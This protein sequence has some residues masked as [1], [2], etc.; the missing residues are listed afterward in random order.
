MKRLITT[1]I[2]LFAGV[3]LLTNAQTKNDFVKGADMGFLTQQERQGVKFYD[4]QGRQRDCMELLKNDYQL[5]AIRMR[6]WVNPRNGMNDKNELLAMAL[7]AKKLGMDLMVDFHYADSWAD[8]SQQPIPA[9]WQGH[10]FEQM[11]NDLRQHTI[12]VLNLLKQNGITPRWVQVGNE[13]ANGLLW[14]MGHSKDN[15]QQYAGFIRAGYDAVKE[16]FPNTIVIVH[17]DRGH[18]QQLYDWNLDIVKKY[19]GRFDMVGMSLYP[20]WARRDHP[21]LQADSIITDCIRN[22]RHVSQKYGCDVMIVETGYEVD[23]SHPEVMDDGRRQLARVIHEARTQTGGHCRGV[24]YWEPQCLP[25][26]HHYNLGAFDSKGRPTAIMDGFIEAPVV[27]TTDGLI[28]GTMQE[29]TMAYLGIPYARVERFMPPQP[30][31]K[32]QGIRACDHWGPQS[33]QP[34][35]RPMSEAEMSEQCCALNVWTTTNMNGTDKPL[36]PVMLWLH[37]GGFDSGTSAW[38]PGQQLAKKDVVVVSVNHRLN[39]LGFLDLSAVSDKY[40][41]SGNVGMLDVVQALKWIRDNIAKFGGDPQNVTVFGESGGGGKVGTLMCM[42]AAQGL[43]HKAI[44]MSGTILNVNTHQ[45]TQQ[46]GKA[47][48]KELGISENQVDRIK[49]V[50]YQQLYQAGQRAMAASIGTRKPGTPMMWGFGPTPDGETLL[51]QPFQPGFASISDNIPLMIG[52][53]FNELQRLHYNRQMTLEEARTELQKT[54]GNETDDYIAAFSKTYPDY[55]PQDLLSIDWL[56]R[57]KTI[58]T[59]DHITSPTS[60]RPQGSTYMYMFNWRSPV[61]KGS[62]HG[63]E[64][65]FCFN[66][67]HQAPNIVPEPTAEDRQLANLMSSVWAQFAHNGNPNIEGLPAWNA[68]TPENGELMVFDH[69]C[70]TRNNPDREL[71]RIIDRHCFRQLDKFRKTQKQQPERQQRREYT[72]SPVEGTAWNAPGNMNPIIPGYFADPTIR[73]F[74]DTYYIYATTD[75]TGNGYGPAQVW[76]SK[77]FVNWKNIVMNWPTTEVVWA[78][79]VVQQPD[80]KYRYY[81]CEPCNIN[82]GES[83]SPIGPW[84][85]ILGKEDA[86]MVPDRYI[87]NVITLDPQLFRDDDGC[88]YLYFTTWGIYKGFGCGVAKLNP[89]SSV[90]SSQFKDAR[91]WNEN[92]PFPIAADE[93]FSEKR[94]IPNTELKDIFEAPFVFKRNGIYYFTYSSG[95]CH[96]D[97][98]RVQYAVSKVG[99]MGPFTYKGELLTTNEDETVHGP[100]HHSILEQDGRYYIVY[101]RHNNP[102]SVHGFNRQVCIDE[103]KF[104]EEGNILRVVP[105]HNARNVSI[106]KDTKH[107]NLAYGAKVTA[108]SY[109]DEWFKPEYAVDDNNATLWKAARCNWD[110]QKPCTSHEEWLQIDLGKPMK[111]NEVWTQFEY[112][113]FFYQYRI[114]TSTD[115]KNWTMFANRTNNTMQGSPM[116]DKGVV[117]AQYLRIT[118]TDTQKNGHMPAIWNVKVW[119]KAPELPDT[120]VESNDGYPGMHK[121]D[122]EASE[123]DVP[124]SVITLN[125]EMLGLKSAAKPFDVTEVECGGESFPSMTFKANKPIRA[126]VKDGRWG[127]FFNGTQQLV[128]EKPLPQCYRYNAPYTIAAWVLSTKVGPVSTVASLSTSRADLATTEFRLGT[129]PQTGLLNHNGS[130]ESCGAPDE[131]KAGEGKWQFWTVTYDGWKEKVYLNGKLVKE[132]NN[133]L[134][135]RPDGHITIGADG[136]GANNFMGYINFLGIYPQSMPAEVV[137]FLYKSLSTEKHPSLGD[138]DFEEIDPDSKFTLSDD[139][140]P[141]FTKKEPFTL[142]AKT[143]AFNDDPLQN[144][145][146][147]YQEVEGDFV[148]MCRVSDME[149]LSQSAVKGYNE[150]GLLLSN[151]QGTYYQLGA[152]PLYNCG[153]MLTILGH[154]GRPQFPNYK[155]YDFDPILQFE[156]RGNQLFARTSKDGKEWTNMPGSPITLK[157]PKVAIG[158]YQTTYSDNDSW[159]K[160]SDYVIYVKK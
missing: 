151:G 127:L 137:E 124:S 109:Y 77:D 65:C 155:G 159:A 4:L 26:L 87:H 2:S 125:V 158:S 10:S 118:I 120:N 160:L 154:Q 83:T 63:N 39:I 143:A 135:I 86:V 92:N 108:S 55:T 95:S 126:R 67:L 116:I 76:V 129:D 25:G 14:P 47:V 40:R 35:N 53:T 1:A 68:Y 110:S 131:I 134:M 29:G 49:D 43:F 104:D 94:L 70:Y 78:P 79:D 142:S 57:P 156:R 17:L 23:E 37:G 69:R 107:K 85:N 15:P 5:S 73:K 36:K 98:Y 153:N 133:F 74:G 112:A 48:L 121:K 56:F 149:G 61:S 6:V 7:R 60:K 41:Y 90:H 21:E 136:T 81:Y 89:Q 101:H 58:I 148:V 115:G 111:F 145:G 140:K 54:F 113:T 71:E 138:D 12:D 59:A 19:G 100:G 119:Q 93:F 88:E 20:Y 82:I 106:F 97:T 114:E 22:I 11:K 52:T 157:N 152:F 24:F 64:L 51:Q 45:M 80:G 30:V 96:T 103:L 150:C 38:D 27:S 147:I 44:I 46:L 130:F 50:P 34:T 3:A 91:F 123:R 31:E 117:K 16:V 18:N 146:Y 139:M 9:A 32:W 33:M 102:K 66:R 99:P 75:G 141:A 122:V 42:P 72:P 105:T 28:S 144:G 13:T 62:V 84:R 8:P 132:Q 128:S